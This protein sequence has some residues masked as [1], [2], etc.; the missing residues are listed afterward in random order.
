MT[1]EQTTPKK[2]F[3]ENDLAPRKSARILAAKLAA[4]AAD[5]PPLPKSGRG[6]GLAYAF[7]QA[8]DV[9]EL[10]RSR[11][12]GQ[13]VFLSISVSETGLRE[14]KGDGR[15][16]WVKTLFTFIDIDSEETLSAW[17]YGA[18]SAASDKAEL[19]ATTESVKHFLLMT[20]LI[21]T[22]PPAYGNYNS[23]PVP[24]RNEAPPAG[25]NARENA[26]RQSISGKQLDWLN[27]LMRKA[28][29]PP[30]E[31]LSWCGAK[32]LSSIPR[33][34]FNEIKDRLQRLKK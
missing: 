31:I 11:L 29:V 21:P 25:Q 26:S 7:V 3:A 33:A 9:F 5:L 16:V 1:D 27:E 22:R 20:F 6:D 34:E 17:G 14:S 19:I 13:G 2:P 8:A 18:A 23:P 28:N 32:N 30:E 12:A 24:P 15:I 4:I 10:V